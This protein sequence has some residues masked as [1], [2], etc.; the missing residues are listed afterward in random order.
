[1]AESPPVTPADQFGADERYRPLSGLA[2]AGLGLAL[3]FATIIVAYGL[4]GL[5]SGMP[6]LLGNWHLF[7]LLPLAGAVLSF[8]AQWQIRNSEGTRA[9]QGLATWGLWLSVLFGLGYGAYA[10]ATNLAVQWQAEDFLLNSNPEDAKKGFFAKLKARS[11]NR[12]TEAFLLTRPPDLRLSD[13]EEVERR[14]TRPTNSAP[15]GELRQFE[16][17]PVVRIVRQAG[18]DAEVRLLNVRSCKYEEGGYWVDLVVEVQTPDCKS[19][20]VP[21][22]VRSKE[23][24]G[25]GREWYVDWTRTPQQL[26]P[27]WVTP[28]ER[29]QRLAGLWESSM[30]FV[31]GW[32]QQLGRKD[33]EEANKALCDRANFAPVWA[34]HSL[35]PLP[36]KLREQARADINRVFD[37]TARDRFN[38]PQLRPENR[39]PYWEIDRKTKR[40]RISHDVS[41]M[42]VDDR[43]ESQ[44]TCHA[45]IT[46]ERKAGEPLSLD[47]AHPPA[48]C[49]SRLEVT[50]VSSVKPGGR[51]RGRGPG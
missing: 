21:M 12:L 9:G 13:L 15:R 37:R 31:H 8:L 10:V 4:V 42:F 30:R 20:Q 44:Y 47:P 11:P 38:I 23:S 27:S 14:F 25:S 19:V 17:N 40:L 29:G 43:M 24:S 45:T 28:T 51:N 48:W 5:F 16:G 35:D 2:I 22:T 46:V 3:L 18:E 50:S 26:D 33:P 1:M 6:I 49:I 36:P 39:V 7:L 41:M 34:P 32:T